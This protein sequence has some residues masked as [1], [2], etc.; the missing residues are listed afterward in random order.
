MSPN[1][2]MNF[3]TTVR[4]CCRYGVSDREILHF[5]QDDKERQDDKSRAKALAVM[6]SEDETLYQNQ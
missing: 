1:P 6:S 3:C 5:V 2:G 4:P